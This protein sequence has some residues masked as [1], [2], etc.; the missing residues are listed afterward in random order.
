MQ[1]VQRPAG[2]QMVGRIQLDIK[3]DGAICKLIAE[4]GYDAGQ[5]ARS[6]K[7]AVESRIAD[8]KY[9]EEEGRIAEGQPLVR[10][11]V[12]LSKREGEFIYPQGQFNNATYIYSYVYGNG[13]EVLGTVLGVQVLID[14]S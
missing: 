4:E 10:Y 11:V 9:L 3:Q 6:L 5:N 2:Q 7:V 12:D 13:W 14:C 1:S 8:E